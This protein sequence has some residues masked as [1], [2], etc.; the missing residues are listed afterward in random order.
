MSAVR[1]YIALVIVVGIPAGLSMWFLIHPFAGFWRRRGPAVAYSAVITLAVV[2]AAGIFRFRKPLLDLE[3]GFRWPLAAAGILLAL[4]AAVL[5]HFYRRQLSV[6][7]LLG[8]PEISTG[9]P[10]KLLTEGIYARMR[11]PRYAGLFLEVLGFSLIANYAAPYLVL[12]AMV[13]VLWLTIRLEERELLSRFGEEYE[14]YRA[15]V[16]A[17]LPRP[18]RHG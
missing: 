3:F 5:E 6:S 2:L 18:S 8:L 13:P 17:L 14:R 1:Y 10:R 11:H 9:R 15:R 16:P 12:V 4:A 7:I